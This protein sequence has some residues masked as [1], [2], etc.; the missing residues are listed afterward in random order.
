MLCR[1]YLKLKNA[2]E[3]FA[4]RLKFIALIALNQANKITKTIQF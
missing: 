1:N 2:Y 3:Q 4:K